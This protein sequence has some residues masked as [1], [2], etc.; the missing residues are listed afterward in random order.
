MDFF[1]PSQ[2]Q[3]QFASILMHT[4][5]L[6]ATVFYHSSLWFYVTMA[7]CSFD[8]NF[9]MYGLFVNASCHGRRKDCG[10]YETGKCFTYWKNPV[11]W[12]ISIGET[13]FDKGQA[14]SERSDEHLDMPS[15]GGSLSLY[16]TFPMDLTIVR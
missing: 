15:G 7:V 3:T 14:T 13:V 4:C 12:R 10:E 6:R 8:G 16:N 11:A 9:D 5:L 2:D 1:G